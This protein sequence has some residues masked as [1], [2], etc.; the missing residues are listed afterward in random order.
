ML[1]PQL[2]PDLRGADPIAALQQRW[3][4]ERSMRIQPWLDDTFASQL[5]KDLRAQPY[6]FRALEP[7]RFNYQ[8]WQLDNT[9]H[10]DCDHGLCAFSRWMWSDGCAW[11]AELTSMALQ[12]PPERNLV[13]TLYSKGCFLDAHSDC[14]EGRALAF[15]IG[16]T[17]S[18]QP[19]A[20]GH[21]EFL[22]GDH[23]VT[24]RRVADWNTLDIFDV[25]DHDRVHQV[26][27]LTS[28][29]ERRAISGWL[30]RPD[31]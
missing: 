14:F 20:G 8:F 7:G 31:C 26:S 17:P 13:S 19:H 30:W 11:L 25:T 10:D 18:S 29:Y 16:L 22:A 24:E 28:A 2:H 4:R 23:T 15:V 1:S 5:L 12:P 27:L 9:P 6:E 21:L 3:A